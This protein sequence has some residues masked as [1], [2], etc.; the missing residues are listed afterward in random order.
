MLLDRDAGAHARIL[1]PETVAEMTCGYILPGGVRHGVDW[2]IG[3]P[4]ALDMDALFGP[5]AFGHTGYTGTL[6]WLE[7]DRDPSL[8]VLLSCLYPDDQ[9]N[10]TPLR[11]QPARAALG[12]PRGSF[13]IGCNAAYYRFVLPTM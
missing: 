12:M 3:S 10:A 6:L 1:E 11:A 13:S 8:I 5:H 9:G 4:Y 2:H 7:R